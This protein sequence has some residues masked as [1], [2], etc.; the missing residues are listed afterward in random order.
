[1]Y[2]LLTF[3]VLICIASVATATSCDDLKPNDFPN[4]IIAVKV[5]DDGSRAENHWI[6]YRDEYCR[7]IKTEVLHNKG[8][9]LGYVTYSYDDTDEN[10]HTRLAPVTI[11]TYAPD[12][13]FLFRELMDGR[14][15]DSSGRIIE[16]CTLLELAE[17]LPDSWREPYEQRCQNESKTPAQRRGS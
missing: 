3:I 12:G 10:A 2:R 13:T 11:D 17:P 4:S 7:A 16:D 8:E 1:M 6:I 5:E 9:L 14:T 15:L